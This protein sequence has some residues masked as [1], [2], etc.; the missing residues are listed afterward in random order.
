MQSIESPPVLFY[1]ITIDFILSLL[2]S[3]K[4]FDMAIPVIY[5]FI[6]RVIVIFNKLIWI[7]KE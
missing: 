5:K 6:K 4:G 1:T 3:V 7:A 2:T